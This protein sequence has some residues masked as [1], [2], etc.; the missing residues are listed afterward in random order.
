[1]GFKR[2]F[3]LMICL[4]ITGLFFY[5]CK[6]KNGTVAST[7]DP[8]TKKYD[9]PTPAIITTSQVGRTVRP[10]STPQ[11]INLDFPKFIPSGLDGEMGEVYFSDIEGDI[12]SVQ[13]TLMEGGCMDFEY[14]AFD[15]MTALSSGDRFLGI[16]RFQQTCKICPDSEGDEIRMRVQLYD[17]AG[18]ESNRRDYSFTCR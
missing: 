14:S 18:N 17:R 3:L 8:L 1:M 10:P 6:R 12:H 15:P 16:F 2:L 11:I 13:F 5:A 9:L 4:T 7:P